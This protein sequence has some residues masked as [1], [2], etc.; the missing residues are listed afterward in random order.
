MLTFTLTRKGVAAIGKRALQR[1]GREAI[2]EAATQW[3]ERYLPLHYKTT[4]FLRYRYAHRDPRTNELKRQRQPWPF[5][6]HN[7]QPATGEV[8]PHV[9]TGRSRERALARPNIDARAPNYQTYVAT[10]KIDAP[11][12]NFSAGSRIDLRDEVT[13]HTPQELSAMQKT[14]AKGFTRRVRKHHGRKVAKL[15]SA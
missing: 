9:F 7:E 11:A 15:L 6:E 13:R 8:L 14:F 2:L 12:Y 3:F 5:G 1:Y 10:V 4:A